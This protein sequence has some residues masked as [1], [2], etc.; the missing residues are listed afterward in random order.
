MTYTIFTSVTL[1]ISSDV[2]ISHQTMSLSRASLNAEELA[3]LL[4]QLFKVT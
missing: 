3:W 1:V 4:A 2:P